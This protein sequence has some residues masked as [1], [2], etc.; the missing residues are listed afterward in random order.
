MIL[1][2]MLQR[3][4]ASLIAGPGLNARPHN[5]RQRV[6]LLELRHLQGTEPATALRD[7]L[8]GKVEF[9]AKVKEFNWPSYPES[10][11][12]EEQHNSR[13]S[14]DKQAK[15]LGKLRDIA[16]DATEYYNDHGDQ[17]LFVGFPLLS[18]PVT[19][20]RQGF[21]SSR[22]LAPIAFVPVTLSVRRGISPGVTM[23]VTG[24]GADRVIPNP[25]LLAWIEQQTG[26]STE[27]L[28]ADESGE[29]P[30]QEIAETIAL[31]A[32]AAGI[33][34][35][36]VFDE[37][38]VLQAVPRTDALPT[39]AEI[40]PCAIIG[41]FPL[42]NPGLLRD[43]KWM[44]EQEPTLVNP[45]QAFLSPK[46]LEEAE[47]NELPEAKEWDHEANAGAK[48]KRD[49]SEELL[50][51]HA[52]PCQAEAVAHARRSAA[53]VIHGPP[54]TGKSQTIA[55]IIGDHLARGERVLFVCDKRTALD[56]V[57]YRLDSMG[58][59]GLCGVI[60]DPQRD[61][62]QLY[63]QIRERLEELAQEAELPDPARKLGQTNTRL[64][65]LHAE[66]RGYFD[67]L[68]GSGPEGESFHQLCGEW[69][70][71]REKGGVDLP[72]VEGLTLENL[73]THRTDAEEI[74]KRAITSRWPESPYRGRLGMTLS[75]WL[76]SRPV[77]I[78]GKL[79]KAV[80][81]AKVVDAT[82]PGGQGGGSGGLG[83]EVTSVSASTAGK[84]P[85]ALWLE[86]SYAAQEQAE[87]R[88]ALADLLEAVEK[89]GLP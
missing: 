17:A 40:L 8:G 82:L 33:E 14:A 37:K 34:V 35:P 28:F 18:I 57:K 87:A 31:A 30:W 12:S 80:G 5:S 81:P 16:E 13:T 27:G 79:E 56:V 6:D 51:T 85:A 44:Q 76:A 49:F 4:Y 3:L 83:V 63:M 25:G 67:R 77:E 29:N 48:A 89:R 73:M 64:N 9:P 53:L 39:K 84:M 46:A 26:Q 78:K 60:H 58:L 59:G 38:T 11:W 70:Q 23:T 10:E 36:P 68:H 41:L 52:D 88:G 7:L 75:E 66:L 54:G 45:V 61:R 20:D 50:V 47:V 19:Q 24:E 71:V 72:E 22:I 74:L 1:R 21:K 42:V 15:V 32:K 69:W 86:A 65:D 55:N 62:T 2:T 43:T